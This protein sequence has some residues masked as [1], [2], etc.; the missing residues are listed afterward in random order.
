MIPVTRQHNKAQNCNIQYIRSYTRSPTNLKYV[1]GS[2]SFFS[3]LRSR[4]L[5]FLQVGL[6]VCLSTFSSVA[7]AILTDYSNMANGHDV[8][9]SAYPPKVQPWR[10]VICSDSTSIGMIA[11][12]P[13]VNVG[14][15]YCVNLFL[16]IFTTRHLQYTLA[17]YEIELKINYLNPYDIVPT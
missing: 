9:Q 17:A 8:K 10:V 6:F 16:H 4:L 15:K 2:R 3:L 1:F 11:V 14:A 7:D 12:V 5:D 13:P